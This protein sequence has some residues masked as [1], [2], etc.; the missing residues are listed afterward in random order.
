MF[1]YSI[2]CLFIQSPF[3]FRFETALLLSYHLYVTLLQHKFHNKLHKHINILYAARGGNPVLASL[4]N[5]KSTE[6]FLYKQPGT[7]VCKL[8]ETI[9]SEFRFSLSFD[10][11]QVA[12]LYKLKFKIEISSS[13][14]S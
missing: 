2:K 5:R 1:V 9:L 11:L 4:L 10:T 6:M 13:I 8:F 14:L 12:I 3:L 7:V